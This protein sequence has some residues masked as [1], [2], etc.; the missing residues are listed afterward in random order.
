MK[1]GTEL[2]RKLFEVHGEEA[3]MTVLDANLSQKKE[4]DLNTQ[5]RLSRKKR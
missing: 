5:L 1:N 2:S 4:A 3:Y